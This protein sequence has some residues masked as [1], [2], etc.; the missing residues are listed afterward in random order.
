MTKFETPAFIKP[1]D[2]AGDVIVFGKS[3]ETEARDIENGVARFGGTWR[4][5]SYVLAYLRSSAILVNHG[6][7]EKCLDEIALPAF[8]MQ[9]HALELFVKRL[10]SWVYELAEFQEELGQANQGVPSK[11]QLERA[12]G[13]HNLESLLQDLHSTSAHFGFGDPPESIS[14]LVRRVGTFEISETWS[15]YESAEKRDGT[16]VH[17]VDE[18][19]ELPIVEMQRD[20]EAL[21]SEVAHRQDDDSTYESNIYE[22]WLYAARS[23]GKAG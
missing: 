2:P 8:Y 5:P 21:Y 10:L 17:H 22:A 9:R 18:E 1:T 19:I 14:S 7:R 16:V 15:R 11:K 6:V 20:L 4:A 3:P 12:K 13:T 23:A